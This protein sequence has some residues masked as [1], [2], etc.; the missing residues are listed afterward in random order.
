M[1]WTL[2][3]TSLPGPARQILDLLVRAEHAFLPIEGFET[4]KRYLSGDGL[5]IGG[6]SSIFSGRSILPVYQIPL[7]LD[8]C[9][10]SS[11]TVFQGK[12]VSD[13]QHLQ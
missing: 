13:I 7:S 5:E 2:L 8:N 9:N 11:T 3:L 1:F 4:F 12:G 10:F 6:P